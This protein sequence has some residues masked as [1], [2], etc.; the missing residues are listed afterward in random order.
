M[1]QVLIPPSRSAVQVADY[2]NPVIVATRNV[3]EMMLDC[4][5][6]R[7]G[8]ALKTPG[9]PQN[10]ISAVIGVTGLITGTIVVGLNQ[11]SACEVLRRLVGTESDTVNREVCDALGELTNMIAGS[12]KAQL[13]RFDLSLSIPN[14]VTGQDC[15]F[16]FPSDV[17]PMVISFDSEVGPFTI[18]VGF[19][20]LAQ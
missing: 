13:A 15:C 9:G 18:E 12:A 19:C 16:H 20:G 8:L 4:V 2:I 6:V 14:V 10:E 5:P 11:R 7:T 3:F 17:H 1:A